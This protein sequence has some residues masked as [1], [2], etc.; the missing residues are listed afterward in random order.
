MP[1]LNSAHI[2]GHPMDQHL[3]SGSNQPLVDGFKPLH[4][5]FMDARVQGDI[6]CN[7]FSSRLAELSKDAVRQGES[8]IVTGHKHFAAPLTVES[9]SS[10]SLNDM[11]TN[12][13]VLKSE[14]TQNFTN[15]KRFERIVVK[16]N[17]KINGNL[18]AETLN[19]LP[20]SQLLE[21][22]ISLQRVELVK[23]PGKLQQLNFQRLN[24]L[25]VD[26]LLS[27]ASD[28]SGDHSEQLLLR[29]QLIIEGNVRFERELQLHS[30]NDLH[31]DEYLT[32][33]VKANEHSV[34]SGCKHFH[35]PVLLTDA[36]QTPSLNGLDPSVLLD[37]TLLRRTPQ[38]IDGSYTFDSLTVGNLDV[39]A[40]NGVPAGSFL[41]TRRKAVHLQGDLYVNQLSINGSLSCL[42][43]NDPLP[44]LEAQLDKLLQ[45]QSWHKLNVLGDALWP[46]QSAYTPLDYLRQ[47]AVRRSGGGANS[48][49]IIAGH[50]I[51]HAAHLGNIQSLQPIFGGNLNLSFIAGDAVL[52]NAR[53][54]QLIESPQ[55]FLA[56]V[57]GRVVNLLNDSHFTQLN[58]ID[59]IRLNASLY[60]RSSR[61]PI[62]GQLRFMTPPAMEK[63][64]VQ[65]QVNGGNLQGVFQEGKDAQWPAVRMQ[66][67]QLRDQLQVGDINGMNLEYLLQHRV[68]LRG[69]AAVEVFGTLSF[70]DLVL[71]ERT[72]LRTINGI[73][74][75]NVV[76]KHSE[77]LQSI[78]G[79]KTFE[80][81]IDLLGPVHI[82]RLNGRDLSESY[83]QSIFTDRDYNIDSL[84]L[85]GAVF[86]ADLLPEARTA[87]DAKIKE[88]SPGIQL[89]QQLQQLEQQLRSSQGNHSKRLLYLDYEQQS[90]EA[91]WR[92][93]AVDETLDMDTAMQLEPLSICQ[94]QELRAQLSR[95][96]QRVYLAN[97]SLSSQPMRAHAR[98]GEIHV[99]AQNYCDKSKL[100]GRIQLSCRGLQHSLGT[101][102][103]VEDLRLLE[104]TNY[105]LLLLSTMEDVRVLRVDHSNCSLSDWQSVQPAGGRI[106]RLIQLN[107]QTLLL[108][109][110]TLHQH[111]PALAVHRLAVESERFE[112]LQLIPGDYDLVEMQDQQLLLSCRRCHRIDV[113]VYQSLEQRFVPLQQLRL[114]ARVQQLLPFSVGSERHLLILTMAGSRNFYLLSYAHIEGWQQRTYGH[115]GEEVLWSWPLL[116]PG[117]ALTSSSSIM[118]LCGQQRCGLVKALIG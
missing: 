64:L 50:V 113:H 44:N 103:H 37:N 93:P 36:L 91:A 40:V 31:W 47:H 63:L 60:R 27:L 66:Q 8:A 55:E 21:Q 45:R 49:Q 9:L 41:D 61:L 81:G 79:T 96:E 6:K 72:M 65:G 42:L 94:L 84:V 95:S 88:L 26:E 74:L 58:H 54:T 67:L 22:G 39:P 112:L 77:Q 43:P 73:P 92:A 33:L 115:M 75:Q 62:E 108:L 111:L 70:E 107:P 32:R 98:Q 71:G 110:S 89:R 80:Q 16:N 102:Q 38:S 106:M 87:S 5:I 118:L 59:L 17:V 23:P 25:A 104:M 100:R 13:M 48:S 117:E 109:S 34:I 10:P 29:K 83:Q 28:H 56:P 7:N 18:R 3:L 15:L 1:S 12:A 86:E 52:R 76:Y 35:G 53:D 101:R 4:I 11:K 46:Q 69:E 2:E 97:V 57:R 78:M 105:S 51:L 90:F 82:M 30:L 85:D 99:K 19:R 24:G 14:T 114:E 116:R 20:I 68:P